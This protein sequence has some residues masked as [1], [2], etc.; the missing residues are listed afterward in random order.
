MQIGFGRTSHVSMLCI[1]LAKRCEGNELSPSF[2]FSLSFT[3]SVNLIKISACPRWPGSVQS[4]G[5]GRVFGLDDV[6]LAVF[7]SSNSNIRGSLRPTPLYIHFLFS[8]L[9]PHQC[10]AG[11]IKFI[12][13]RFRDFL[14]DFPGAEVTPPT[15]SLIS[16][17]HPLTTSDR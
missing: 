9:R 15:L 13:V 16:L 6:K 11:R 17:V 7:V 8:F 10:D 12:A 5:R 4:A 1:H 14:M 2:S 3:S